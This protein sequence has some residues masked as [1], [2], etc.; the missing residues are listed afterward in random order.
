MWNNKRLNSQRHPDK[1]EKKQYNNFKDTT[2][3]RG[4]PPERGRRMA[5]T[6][7]SQREES[8]NGRKGAFHI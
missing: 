6:Y 8:P 2:E 3:N 1:K 4:A 7:F 5:C